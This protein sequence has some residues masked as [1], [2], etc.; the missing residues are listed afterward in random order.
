MDILKPRDIYQPVSSNDKAFNSGFDVELSSLD[1]KTRSFKSD[2]SAT[3]KDQ[4]PLLDPSTDP[5]RYDTASSRRWKWPVFRG[6][7]RLYGWKTGALSAA[8]FAGIS[9][10]I[11]LVVLVWLAT[12]KASSGLVEL[13]IGS[14]SKVQSMDLWVHLAINALSTLLLGGSNYCM[15]CLCAPTRQDVDAAHAKGKWLDI[16]V[17][18]TRNLSRVPIYKSVMWWMFG[19]SSVP[20]HLM[21]N[22][23]FYKSLSTNDYAIYTVTQDFVDGSSYN[24]TED[25]SLFISQLDIVDPSHIQSKLRTSDAYERM[26]KFDCIHAYATDFLTN[27]RNLLLVARND[28]VRVNVLHVEPWFYTNYDPY[29]WL[30]VCDPD[31]GSKI[32]IPTGADGHTLPCEKYVSKVAAIA[33]EWKPYGDDIQY[34]LSERVPETCSYNGNIPI[35]AIVFVANLFKLIGMLWVAFRLRDA[36]LITV[37]DAVQSFLNEP[38]S[39]TKGMCLFT[40]EDVVGLSRRNTHWSAKN[41]RVTEP[42]VARLRALRWSKSASRTRWFLT[43]GFISLSLIVV[44]VLLSI[45]VSAITTAGFTIQDLG[46]GKVKPASIITGWRVGSTGGAAAQVISSVLLAN[47]PQTIFSFLYLNLNGLL[48]SMWVASEWSDFASERKTLRVSKPKGAQRSTHFL[49]L[50]YKVA[51]PLMILSGLL[52]WLISQAIFLVVVAEYNL[53]GTLLSPVAVASCGFSPLAMVLGIAAGCAIII[54]TFLLGFG[55]HY[56]PSMPLAGSCSAAISAACHPPDWDSDAAMKPVKWGVVPDN[57]TSEDDVGH[58][59][60]T[61]GDAWQLQDGRK[62]AGWSTDRKRRPYVHIIEE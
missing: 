10:L 50:P 8:V 20:L 21:Y 32:Q 35:V 37:G 29:Q 4:T 33:D 62:Y 3:I 9:L 16:G 47:L 58:C 13:F 6:H 26:E 44:S 31:I 52:H 25:V 14:C 24:T 54:V 60:V 39:T 7:S 34:C 38:D 22:S 42:R 56:E 55:L 15:Q 48:T 17:P 51:M 30:C 19:L 53:D 1:N 59:S 45:A 28:T 36:P 18:S 49:Q 5:I 12:H 57:L 41:A 23:A 43:I 40:K 11:N 46:F 61:S 27:R 2:F